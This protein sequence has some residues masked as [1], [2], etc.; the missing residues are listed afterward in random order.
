MEDPEKVALYP[1]L[2]KV[3]HFELSEYEIIIEVDGVMV[4]GRIDSFCPKT[5]AFSDTKSGHKNKDGKAPWNA[6]KVRKHMQLPWYSFLIELSEGKVDPIC[7][8]IWIET[9]FKQ[10]TMNFD[11]HVLLNESRELELTGIVKVFKRRI[12]KWERERIRKL[13]TKIAKEIH[14]DYTNYLKSL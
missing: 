3:P 10:K 2:H 1:E 11:G 8:L 6:V 9:A 5:F 13:I 4:K 14:N 7:F 12:A